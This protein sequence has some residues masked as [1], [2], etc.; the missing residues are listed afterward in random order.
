M[1]AESDLLT[2]LRIVGGFMYEIRPRK[3]KNNQNRNNAESKLLKEKKFCESNFVRHKALSEVCLLLCFL[4]SAC[5]CAYLLNDCFVYSR[6]H[7]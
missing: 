5:V 2:N 1:H 4:R 6:L 3:Q 7:S